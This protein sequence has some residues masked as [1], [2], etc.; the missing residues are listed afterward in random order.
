MINFAVLDNIDWDF[1][2][3]LTNT[4]TNAFH[5]YPAKFIPQIPKYFVEQFSEPV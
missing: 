3:A 1:S 4:S 2:K 5:P